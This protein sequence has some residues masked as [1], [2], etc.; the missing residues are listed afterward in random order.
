MIWPMMDLIDWKNKRSWKERTG[1][2]KKEIVKVRQKG[3]KGKKKKKLEKKK[4]W[5]KERKG[6]ERRKRE[7]YE[8]ERKIESRTKDKE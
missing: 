4:E 8:Q 6:G 7:K 1:C 2:T 5:E 3:S